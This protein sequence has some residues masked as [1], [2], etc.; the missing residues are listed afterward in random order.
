M[1]TAVNLTNDRY[2]LP[3]YL[4][5]QCKKKSTD[6]KETL[7]SLDKILC[8]QTDEL[9]RSVSSSFQGDDDNLSE[10]KSHGG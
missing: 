9:F 4:P 2:L 1:E 8:K 7:S 10:I 3:F 5:N 6:G